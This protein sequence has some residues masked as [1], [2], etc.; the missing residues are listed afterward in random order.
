MGTYEI[1]D[2]NILDSEAEALVNTVNCKGVMGR[3]LAL[4]FKQR[5][6]EN[7]DAYR[8]ECDAG[9]MMLGHVHVFE[10]GR[11]SPRYIINFPTKDH[12]RGKSS[13]ANITNGL[14]SLER[15]VK[16]LGVQSIAIPA[17]GC[18]LGG[19]DWSDVR[20]LI[21][22]A[23]YRLPG[24]HAVLFAPKPGIAR[25]RAD[26]NTYT[27]MTLASAVVTALMDRYQRAGIG[28]LISN[29]EVQKLVYFAREAGEPLDLNITQGR[30]GPYAEN[31]R[32]VLRRMNGK[33]IEGYQSEGDF[34]SD[35]LWLKEGAESEANEF[36]AL[37][38]DTV[39]R[40]ARVYALVDG[41]Q[42]QFGLEV[43]ATVHWVAKRT[44]SP[45]LNEVADG[46]W[47]WN[48]RKREMIDRWQIEVC[49]NRLIEQGWIGSDPC[50]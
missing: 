23:V 29:L 10:T 38:D 6:P 48:S 24:L 1:K 5:F 13:L 42:S 43:L 22:S 31:L 46:V 14:A 12:W 17:L 49:L 47:A 3:G 11:M 2:G 34:P 37:Y 45:T 33:Y 39:A 16:R 30:Y 26:S 15:E 19:L 32:H 28:L 50:G 40:L 21:E 7:Y 25:Q 4:Q 36:L 44:A 35:E 8:A 41:F 27:H 20:P 9:R 18:D